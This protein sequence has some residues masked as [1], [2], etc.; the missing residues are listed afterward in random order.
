MK[1]LVSQE[2]QPDNVHMFRIPEYKQSE[3]INNLG[4]AACKIL[5]LVPQP[6]QQTREAIKAYADGNQDIEDKFLQQMTELSEAGISSQDVQNIVLENLAMD[7]VAESEQPELPKL[8]MI[9]T[10]G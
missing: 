6:E 7:A 3:T 5:N 1:D 8:R 10:R 9:D 2:L 4:G